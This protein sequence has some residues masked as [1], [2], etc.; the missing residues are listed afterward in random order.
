MTL[1]KC[2]KCGEYIYE[3]RPLTD[4]ERETAMKWL[5]ET[6]KLLKDEYDKLWYRKFGRIDE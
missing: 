4:K 6:T 3:E 5:E 1:I 2:P